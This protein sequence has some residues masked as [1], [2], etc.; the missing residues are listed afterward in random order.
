[1]S[2]TKEQ[3]EMSKRQARREQIRRKEQRGKIIGISLISIG[4]IL[5]AAL[6]IYS[7]TK[8]I[9]EVTAPETHEYPQANKTSLGDPNAP[10]KIDA[11][12]D[13]QCPACLRFTED[14]E[15]RIIEEF[16]KT[17][18]VYY[19]FHNYPFIDGDGA[20]NGGESD[21]AA[22]ASMCAMEQGKFWDMHA[23]I[24]INW[25]GENIGSFEDRRLRAFAQTI[26]LD[27]GDFDACFES[28]KYKKDIQADF[29]KGKEIGVTGTPSVFVNGQII[30][31]GYIPSYEDIKAEVDKALG[32]N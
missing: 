3:K 6:L 28:N 1:M 10:V 16:V 32:G 11:Y 7:N 26:G 14:V 30:T 31:P 20:G 5:V 25:G 2:D 21:Q 15:P 9:A 4:A 17:G 27:M 19:T 18:K 8:P 24:F 12:E 23:T 29:D 13:F 22:N